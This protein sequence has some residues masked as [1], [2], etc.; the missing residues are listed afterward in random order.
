MRG[1]VYS[2]GSWAV[3]LGSNYR[4]R[5]RYN[6]SVN[7]SY[8]IN[9]AGER[10]LPNYLRNRDFRVVWTHAQDPKARPNS[11]FRANV[12]AGTSQSTRFNPQSEQDYLSN[13]FSSNISYTA[14][15]ASRYNFSLNAR[16]SQNT[17]NRTVDLGLPE[18][19]FSVN[20]IY[21]FRKSQ[22][23]T[24]GKTRWY[25]D[26]S[27]SY[28]MNARNEIRIADSLL[29]DSQMWSKMRNGVNHVIP[30]SHSTRVFNYLNLST[31]LN[32]NERWYFRSIEKDWDENLF[33]V[34]SNDT[35]FGRERIDTVPGFKAIRDF[36][37]S[38][39]LSTR[40]YGMKNFK[41]GTV[42]AVRH[43]VSPNLSFS[44][45]PDF[46]DPFWG[47]YRQYYNPERDNYIQY[48]IFEGALYSGPQPNRSGA[49]GYNITNNLEM[50]VRSRKDT[51]SGERKISLIDNFTISGGYDLARDSLNWSDIRLSGRT[52][53]FGN[54]DVTYSSSYTLYDR[55]ARGNYINTFLYEQ[56]KKLLQLNNTSW[57]LS[58]NYNLSSQQGLGPGG[59]GGPAQGLAGPGGTDPGAGGMAADQPGA[60]RN[61]A[62]GIAPSPH[63]V[64][65]SVP[66]SLNFSYNF[67]YN[68][69]FQHQLE[70]FDRSYVQNL[71][72]SGNLGLT[73]MWRIG[74]RSG[75][76]FQRKEI[77]YT[78]VDI[79]RD[80]HCWEMTLNWIPFGFRKSYNFTIRVKSS[81]LQDLK[82][83]RRTHHLDR[84]SF[85]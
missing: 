81:V 60:T 59:A 82:L 2:R 67:T 45:R 10:G 38:T 27:L 22:T 70:Q 64:D 43:V 53:L 20:R 11:Q 72:V 58:F 7:L 65:Y 26:I 28:S 3:R 54:F 39:G 13:T 29:F 41:K 83:S 30:I 15:W 14:N 66:W 23:P 80:L 61:E 32:Y 79:Y 47:Y 5:Y 36:S 24:G 73:P 69:R 46:A 6:G 42:R 8:A 68:S 40:I 25:E 55:D 49:L 31:S 57:S 48:A 12:N 9:V 19:A 34:V 63:A 1:D 84:V 78:S 21:P 44:F 85:N 77:T 18:M 17:I 33:R 71:S 52:R 51:I 74:F 50:K 37:F 56:H 16:H 4:M 75:Y 62:P 35:I 76:D